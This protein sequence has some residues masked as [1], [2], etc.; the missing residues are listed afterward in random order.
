LVGPEFLV[1]LRSVTESRWETYVPR[2][3]QA[4]GVGGLDWAQGTKWRGGTTEAQVDEAQKRFGLVFPPDYRRFL[5]TLHTTDPEMVGAFYEGSTLVA[6]TGRSLYDWLGD[7][8]PIKEA[9]AWPVDG[10]LWSIEADDIWHPNWGQRPDSESGR[11]EVIRAL[12]E[13]GPPLIPVFGHRYLVGIPLGEGNPV[14]S[15]YGADVIV[16]ADDLEAYL[17]NEL[18]G[19]PARVSESTLLLDSLGFWRDVIAGG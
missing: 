10:L 5:V 12:A 14:L 17:A 18:A 8:D 11:V 13:S 9:L 7:P 4:A 6:K 1:W 19:Q 15:M 16:Y 3:F 2:D